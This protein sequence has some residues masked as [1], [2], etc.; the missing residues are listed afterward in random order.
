MKKK[1]V[2][3]NLYKI[4]ERIKETVIRVFSSRMFIVMIAFCVMAAILV[5]RVFYL[6]I[7][8]GESYL[9]DYKLQ[10]QKTREVQGTRG[11][12]L[13]RNGKVLAD[14]VLAYSVTIEDN[15]DYD[16]TAQKNKELNKTIRT[17]IDIIEKNGDSV[18]NSFGII[19]NDNGEYAYSSEGTARL[20]FIADVFGFATIDKLSEEQK[21]YTA[22]DMI[23]YLC[24]DKQY[25]YG[26]D[27]EKYEKEDVLKLVNIRYAMS[28]NKFRKYIATTIATNVSDKTVAEIMERQDELTGVSIE[29]SSIRQYNN[30]KYF[31]SIIGYTGQIS[32]E[33]YNALS[34]EEQK[35]YSLTDIVGKAG[36]EKSMDSILQGKKGET[37]FYVN[38]VGRV[39]DTK[40]VTDAKAGNDLYLS[41]DSDLQMAAYNILEEKLA[42]ILLAKMT[43][44]LD[45]DRSK[46]TDADNIIIPV[47]DVY[48]AFFENQILDT[49]HFKASD[50]KTTEKQVLELYSRE[51]EDAIAAI[52]NE[53]QD[54]NG[55]PYKSLSKKMKAYIDYV[56]DDL[57]TDKSGILLKD[58][59]DK[60][61][62][63][64]LAWKEDETISIHEY[65]NY[66]IS[67]NWIDTSKLTD[68][69]EGQANYSDASEVYQAIVQYVQSSIS[70][71]S[72]FEKIIYKYMIKSG[73]LTG[74]Q[75][76]LLL[77]E[78]NIIKYDETQYNRLRSGAVSAYEF[79]REKI[80]NLE[81][82]P[83]ELGL[84]PCSGSIV[85]TDT[86]SGQVLAMVSYPGYDNNRLAN[87]IDSNYF[88]KLS[89]MNSRP[90]Y[91]RATQEKTAPGSTYKPLVAV[92]GL[93]EGVINTGSIISCSGIFDKIFPN[94]RCWVYPSAHGS[95]NVVSAIQH[96]CNDF[97]YEVGY[98]LG[99]Q[100][101]GKYSTDAGTDVLKQ[102]AE[103]FGLGD[104]TGVEITESAPQISDTDAVRS[105]IGQGNNNYT[106]AGLARYITAIANEGT[107]YDLSLLD[108]VTDVNGKLVKDYEPKVKNQVEGVSS[109]TWDAV[110]SGMR[111]VVTST[112]YT[113]GSLGNFELSGK[114]GTAQQSTTH[115]NHGLFVGFGPSSDPEIAFAIRIA[116][117]Y[118]STYPSEVGRDIIRYYYNLDEKDEI[119]T[120]HASSL[121]SVVSGD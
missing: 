18:I 50:A 55:T 102:Y 68:Y 7:V 40:K 66:A 65:L 97:F 93:T 33:E 13:D 114:T 46:I 59:I 88:A 27:E 15:G 9:N 57:L 99:S 53:M 119:V 34:D 117:G 38:N 12:I 79:V 60:G 35:N 71:D 111:R 22:D 36:I 63:T 58:K 108:K 6:Q 39:I 8:K 28:L 45:Y 67:K 37:K 94:P 96:S 5:Q 92:A 72:S 73:E 98:R 76:C 61:D 121:G 3:A 105:S 110:Q 51:Q 31:A 29:E 25:G 52:A 30:S 81:I 49:E 69:L 62:A 11:R 54:E 17:V 70:T 109:S 87:T 103:Q 1:G 101:T 16:T 4:W 112:S 107:V 20:R 106:T 120:G 113:F 23:H 116:N 90:M 21:N 74:R 26:I 83:G 89:V 64:Y 2:Q 100:S 32:Q 19:L 10:I 48:N 43:N 118:N 41:I 24:T 80:R 14:N 78:Q 104:T 75:V 115:P 95:E 47:G 86:K 85:I 42:A 56:V 84:E 77:Y 91:N 44:Q 82:T